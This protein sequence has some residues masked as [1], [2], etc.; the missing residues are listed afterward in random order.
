MGLS[1]ANTGGG[2]QKHALARDEETKGG[3]RKTKT[4]GE[5]KHAHPRD[6]ETM[7]V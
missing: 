4:H 3:L 5:Q 6:E 7:R 1:T 2:G